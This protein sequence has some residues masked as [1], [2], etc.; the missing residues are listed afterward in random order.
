[1]EAYSPYPIKEL[2]EVLPMWNLLPP[3][4]FGAGFVGALTAFYL[5]YFIAAIVYPL[6]VGGTATE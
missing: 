2:D 1:M 3:I 5:Q 6:N 4:V